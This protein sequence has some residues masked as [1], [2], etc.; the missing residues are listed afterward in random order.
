MKTKKEYD[1]EITLS[2][3][4]S[5]Y[6]KHFLRPDQFIKLVKEWHNCKCEHPLIEGIELHEDIFICLKCGKNIK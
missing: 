6:E 1:T 2:E 5:H 3:L 4:K